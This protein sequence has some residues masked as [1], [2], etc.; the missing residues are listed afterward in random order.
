MVHERRSGLFIRGR[1]CDPRLDAVQQSAVLAHRFEA[2]GMRD[3]ATRGHPVHVAGTNHLM[4]PRLSR[5][6][7]SPAYRYVIVA[8]PMCGCGRTSTLRGRIAAICRTHVIEE[9]ERPDH[10][11]LR[12]RQHAPDFEA[13][14]IAAP[15][16]D[17]QLDRIVSAHAAS[18]GRSRTFG[19][20]L[21]G[22]T[23]R[24][25]YPFAL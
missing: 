11:A 8:S 12:P 17:D 19:P 2:L 4:K 20:S 9:D 14:E 24:K 18:L 25:T 13:A 23:E 1:Q 16:L 3:A 10:A 21:S 6:T 15:P 22:A 7:I 5:C